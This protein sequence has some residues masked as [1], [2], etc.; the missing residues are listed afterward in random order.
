MNRPIGHVSLG[1]AYVQ[2]Q[3]RGKQ[4]LPPCFQGRTCRGACP[5][6]WPSLAGKTK[7]PRQAGRGNLL[8]EFFPDLDRDFFQTSRA[9]V[10]LAEISSRLVIGNPTTVL[11]LRKPD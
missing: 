11:S 9:A 1:S 6:S 7:G 2:L 10:I 8:T 3:G 5:R 4:A